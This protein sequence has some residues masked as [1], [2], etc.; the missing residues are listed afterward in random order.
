MRIST[1]DVYPPYCRACHLSFD[2]R[3]FE[4]ADSFFGMGTLIHSDLCGDETYM[5]QAK[6]TQRA[7]FGDDDAIQ[8]LINEMNANKDPSPWG[9]TCP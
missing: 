7:L 5:P 2:D 6:V 8:L 9:A 4:T 1:R 3:T